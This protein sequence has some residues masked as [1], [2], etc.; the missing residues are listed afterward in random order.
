MKILIISQHFWPENFPINSLVKALVNRG[1]QVTVLTGMP[2]YPGGKLY[3]NYQR[4]LPCRE[5]YYGAEITRVPVIPRGKGSSIRLSLN[6]LSFVAFASLFAPLL[7]KN[8]SEVIFV[9]AP[10]PIVQA[11]PAIFLRWLRKIPACLWVQDLWPESL[12]ATKKIKSQYF[13]GLVD[14]L[15]SCIYRHMDVNFIQS[16]AFYPYIKRY[17]I[18]D[19]K[20]QYL[21]NTT[22]D[23]YRPLCMLGEPAS[24]LP[25]GFRILFAGNIGS[26][27]A[28]S[29]ILD[30]V[31]KLKNYSDIKWIFAGDGSE[32]E[33][34]QQQII[35]KGLQDSI[36]WI[37][38]YPATEMPY[39]FS[40]VDVL[41]VSL[42]KSE[43][44]ALTIPSKVQSYLASGRPIL[45]A[46]DGEGARIIEEAKAGLS[47]PAED[48][49]KLAV[50]VLSLRAMSREEREN[51]GQNG[52]NYFQEHFSQK[53]LIESVEF[54]LQRYCE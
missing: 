49:E 40:A 43:I 21:P 13:I 47:A 4:F 38:A 11:I 51:L 42:I 50:A 37:G 3:K 35:A 54:W 31:E 7:C 26:A 24:S 19:D 53:K 18:A 30:T 23:F 25:Q 27:Q 15:V 39:F 45:A 17:G 34:L 41:L 16:R 22:D 20:I 28:I 9:Y 1:H 8:N 52:Y 29:T 44:F 10:S 33:F 2:N 14:K 46:L 6:Y 12:S 48:P 5:S 36:I 32:R